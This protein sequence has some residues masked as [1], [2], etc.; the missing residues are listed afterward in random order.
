M[1][2]RGDL[3]SRATGVAEEEETEEDREEPE[4]DADMP[5]E[6]TEDEDEEAVE[7]IDRFLD[8][9]LLMLS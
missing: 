1:S 8:P 7:E 2:W 5:R 4:V 3:G 9:W 6:G